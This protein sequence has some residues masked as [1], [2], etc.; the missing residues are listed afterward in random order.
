MLFEPLDPNSRFRERRAQALPPEAPS[1]RGPGRRRARARAPS[2]RAARSSTTAQPG[3]RAGE[4]KPHGDVDAPRPAPARRRPPPL[5][6]PP[7]GRG[8][9]R[10]RH[11][12]ARLAP[13]QA[14]GVH[15]LTQRGPE[16][17]RAR[18]Q[19]RERRD[20]L[21]AVV[22]ARSRSQVGA[23]MRYYRPREAVRLARE[24]RPLP[25]RPGRRLRGSDALD[26]AGPTWRS[27]APDGSVWTSAAGLG[28]TNP[29]DR[30]VWDYNVSIAE[31]AA[32]AGFDEIQL[33]YV[34][35]PS[36][37]DIGQRGL[38]RKTS[39]PHGLGDPAVRPVRGEAAEAARRARLGGRLRA[40]GDARPRDRADA[41]ADLA[42]PRRRLPD[43]VPVALLRR[44][45]TGS[46][47]RTR[48]RARRSSTRSQTSG[49]S[50]A[51]ARP[52]S[53][54]GCRTSRSAGR[55]RSTEVRAQ[56]ESARLQDARGYLLWNPS[57]VYTDGALVPPG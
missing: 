34:R 31:V 56:I 24:A 20:R 1:S 19:G 28:W 16:H 42:L 53:S 12:R 44:A 57:G 49:A 14:R 45:S 55:T 33:D 32:R 37:G 51:A 8:P 6:G 54:R 7:P 18:R 52:T 11:G 43:D 27:S 50:C 17:D 9:R 22:G 2:S 5:D 29:Y 38:P 3:T 40:L 10:P 48:S 36:D 47:T 26:A 4:A 23:A 15:A 41:A 39:T 21:R 46:P 25:D 30:R 13:R 35:F